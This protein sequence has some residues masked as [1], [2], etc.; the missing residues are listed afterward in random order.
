MFL[1][2]TLKMYLFIRYTEDSSGNEILPEFDILCDL[3]QLHMSGL[4]NNTAKKIKFSTK[5]LFS[6]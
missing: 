5:D 1:S 2:I 4:Q 6:K 3:K